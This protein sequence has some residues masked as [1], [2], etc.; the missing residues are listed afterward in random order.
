MVMGADAA[1][2][3]TYSFVNSL[4]RIHHCAIIHI[5]YK[6]KNGSNMALE[7]H[8]LIAFRSMQLE[9]KPIV[10]EIY[11]KMDKHGRTSNSSKEQAAE[12]RSPDV[13]KIRISSESNI[14]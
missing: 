8:S 5:K 11:R 2:H 7:S 3:D 12:S 9:M 6:V 13:S 4:N 14:Y 1:T 10:L